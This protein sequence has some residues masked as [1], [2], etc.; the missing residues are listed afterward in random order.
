MG[1]V[2][3][4]PE[5]ASILVRLSDAVKLSLDTLGQM[6]AHAIEEFTPHRA[7]I[8]TARKAAKEALASGLDAAASLAAMSI[9]VEAAEQAVVLQLRIHSQ[10]LTAVLL[11]CF[12]LES[13]VNVLA[14]FLLAESDILG[15][16]RDG[17][18]SSADVLFQAIERMSPRDKW[19]TVARLGKAEG[20]D[21]SRSPWQDFDVLFKFRDDHVHDKVVAYS[22]DRASK[23]YHNR[24]PDPVSGLLSLEHA[25]FAATTYWAM[26]QHVH[27]L[28]GVPAVVFHRH[29]DLSPWPSKESAQELAALAKQYE[30]SLRPEV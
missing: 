20:F 19:S 9:P 4:F 10:A 30:D 14:Y 6:T 1:A 25:V 5:G 29:Y 15:L 2:M 13:Y 26:V 7:A 21:R 17:R 12:A 24:F 16:V 22:A 28:V 27:D 11:C 3:L 8:R 23:R 18:K